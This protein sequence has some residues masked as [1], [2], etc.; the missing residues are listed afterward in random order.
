MT[1]VKKRGRKPQVKKESKFTLN[2]VDDKLFFDAQV[3]AGFTTTHY[4]G[5][6]TLHENGAKSMINANVKSVFELG[7]GLGFFLV[8]ASRVGLD[9]H[10]YDI[11]PIERDFALSKGIS[12]ERYVLGDGIELNLD[13]HYDACYCVEV[14]EHI[15]DDALE[16]IFTQ[17][18]D[19]CEQLFFTSTPNHADGDADWGHINIKSKEE[20]VYFMASI[21][22]DYVEDWRTVTEWGLRF[23]R[24]NN[25]VK[26]K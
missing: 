12:P 17:V 6:V 22:Y 10:G 15:T 8:G 24:K 4:D 5:L 3:N 20:W 13:R 1:E 7:S 2:K 19:K 25:Y 11:N 18:I 16:Y 23:K 26:R 21:G 14:A 9:A